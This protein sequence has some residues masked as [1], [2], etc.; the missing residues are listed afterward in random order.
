[1]LNSWDRF[2]GHFSIHKLYT[3]QEHSTQWP[4]EY[5]TRI[6]L[7]T[8]SF[9]DSTLVFFSYSWGETLISSAKSSIASQPLNVGVPRLH[10][11]PSSVVYLFSLYG[12]LI[13]TVLN[14]TY[15]QNMCAISDCL[16]EPKTCN[17]QLKP[18]LLY[19][20]LLQASQN[21]QIENSTLNCLPSSPTESLLPAFVICINAHVTKLSLPNPVHQ[22]VLGIWHIKCSSKV[23]TYLYLP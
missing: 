18:W 16:M 1:M 14:I 20:T 7:L 21:Q 9:C 6:S 11:G 8:F 4:F 5:L 17:I 2:C 12:E 15:I 3:S 23:S 22:Q 10:P 19:L 13:Q